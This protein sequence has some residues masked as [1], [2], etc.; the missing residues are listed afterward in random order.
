MTEPSVSL[1]SVS[2]G[3]C[4]IAETDSVGNAANANAATPISNKRFI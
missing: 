2:A 4:G 3:A 1:T